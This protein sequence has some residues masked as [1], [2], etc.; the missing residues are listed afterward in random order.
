[1]QKEVREIL[2][3][4]FKFAVLDYA[5]G[6]GSVTKACCEFEVPRSTF[7]EWKKAFDKV[8]VTISRML[9]SLLIM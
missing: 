5:Q 6:I 3:I 1:M 9:L 2:R 4:R 8:R 7:Y